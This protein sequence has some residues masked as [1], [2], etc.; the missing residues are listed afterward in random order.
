MLAGAVALLVIVLIANSYKTYMQGKDI[1]LLKRTVRDLSEELATPKKTQERPSAQQ[2][3]QVHAVLV[4]VSKEEEEE[5]EVVV[6]E[7]EEEEAADAE[8][9]SETKQQ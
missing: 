4:D 9:K 2:S 8:S 1:Q 6:E 5:E 3:P 7:E